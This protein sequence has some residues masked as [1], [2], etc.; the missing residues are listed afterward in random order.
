MRRCYQADASDNVATML[1]NASKEYVS[2]IGASEGRVVALLGST[3]LG[4]KVGL[5][6][7]ESGANVIKY[8]ITVGIA[9]QAR[10][11]C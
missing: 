3:P 11:H 9:G 7:I 4:H 1:Q 5:T 6:T 10:G 8:G 2:V